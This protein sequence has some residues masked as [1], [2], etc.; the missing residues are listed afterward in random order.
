MKNTVYTIL[1]FTF[2]MQMS[3][4]FNAGSDIEFLEK[5]ATPQ[6]F[7]E[8]SSTAS[9][10]ITAQWTNESNL[11]L[12]DLYSIE[13]FSNATCT[14]PFSF[15]VAVSKSTTETMITVGGNGDYS[16]RVKTKFS[17]GSE[18]TSACSSSI[19]VLI[20]SLHLIFP[21]VSN[22][23]HLNTPLNFTY[24]G[25]FAE[26]ADHSYLIGAM[27]TNSHVQVFDSTGLYV[28]SF[29]EGNIGNP[30][31]IEVSVT[32]DIYVMDSNYI[33]R[34]DSSY[35]SLGI[36]DFFSDGGHITS[37]A[38]GNIYLSHGSGSSIEQYDSG[39]NFIG[40]YASHPSITSAG[41][42]IFDSTG[43][44]WVPN[45]S[46]ATV[47]VFEPGGAHFN[48][49]TNAAGTPFIN[50]T[51]VKIDRNGLIAV[52]DPSINTVYLFSPG[53]LSLYDTVVFSGSPAIF[54]NYGGSLS[55]ILSDGNYVVNDYD[56]TFYHLRHISGTDGSE[57]PTTPVVAW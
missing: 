29:G 14:E 6:G 22:P 25:G 35:N 54:P 24:I 1:L 45:Q 36:S 8:G 40:T 34:F 42:M 15:S 17:S 53:V 11:N 51:S 27:G 49:I 33:Y 46:P 12:I 37:D 9:T 30:I 55:H 38:A 44:L 50:I 3:G 21:L 20:P 26:L 10:S 52:S 4:C 43:N 31:D 13:L 57:N 18:R 28:Q 19:T 48:S 41:D 23:A 7:T 56:G 5:K 47:E 32:G 16:Y 39:L 2:S